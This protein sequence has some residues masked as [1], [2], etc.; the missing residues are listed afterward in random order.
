MAAAAGEATSTGIKETINLAITPAAVATV[1][2]VE[3][4]AGEGA[5]TRVAE[6]L[7]S[8][9]CLSLPF[10]PANANHSHELKS[11]ILCFLAKA[12]FTEVA[13]VFENA[14]GAPSTRHL[15]RLGKLGESQQHMVAQ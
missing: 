12:A 15:N 13:P 11:V 2:G 8:Q 3:G 4:M 1:V 9:V 6:V 10:R 14:A 5:G 7:P